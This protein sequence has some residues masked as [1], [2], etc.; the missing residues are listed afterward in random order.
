MYLSYPEGYGHAGAEGDVSTIFAV[1]SS[2]DML[3][4][5]ELSIGSPGKA[6]IRRPL[7]RRSQVLARELA[8][9]VEAHPSPEAE[10]AALASTPPTSDRNS[11][12]GGKRRRPES[13]SGGGS[14][15]D[16]AMGGESTDSDEA[17]MDVDP[18]SPASSPGKEQQTPAM[19]PT[20]KNYN[21]SGRVTRS[22]AAGPAGVHRR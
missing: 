19:P 14:P 17:G 18:Q 9:K 22:K 20:V 12:T 7:E 3:G 16:A 11:G 21:G 13:S 15:V 8:A 2:D 1:P 4:V 5:H 6:H 10:P